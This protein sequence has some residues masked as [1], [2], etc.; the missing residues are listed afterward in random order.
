MRLSIAFFGIAAF[1][2]LNLAAGPAATGWTMD[3]VDHSLLGELLAKY[4][5]AGEVDYAGFKADEEKLDRYLRQ[6][7]DV[8]PQD[9]S[10]NEQL[11]F[12]I[13]AYNAYTI[14]LVLTGYPNI[15]S[16]KDLGTLWRSPWKKDFVR[17][18]G[19]TMTLDDIEHG[20]IRPRFQDPRIHFAVNCAARS[21]PPL[22]PE[23]YRGD[24]LDEQLDGVTRA[25]VNNPERN[26]LKGDTLHV[27]RIFDWYGEDFKEGIVAFFIQYGSADLQRAILGIG[28]RLKIRYL[29]Y[30]WSLNGK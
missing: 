23:P 16:I 6:L 28:D 17:L 20:I 10:R 1:V 5:H 19:R 22:I 30:D 8:R 24:T 13:N 15:K 2:A 27:S 11:A 4:V 25:F 9:L 7:E 26:Y 21:C 18:E 14:K 29:S 12:Y 3:K